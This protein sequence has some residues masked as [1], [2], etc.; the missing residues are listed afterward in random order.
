MV[1]TLTEVVLNGEVRLSFY[2]SID[3]C[4]PILVTFGAFGVLFVNSV[5]GN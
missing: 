2:C 3:I 5:L 1:S 4:A